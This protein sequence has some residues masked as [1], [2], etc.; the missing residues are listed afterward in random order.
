MQETPGFEPMKLLPLIPQVLAKEE[1]Q[2]MG[3]QIAGRLA[4]RVAARVIRNLLLEE[5]GNGNINRLIASSQQ[6]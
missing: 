2:H 6:K 1:T 4:Q 3:Q 5:E